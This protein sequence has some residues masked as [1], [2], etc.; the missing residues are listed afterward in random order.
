LPIKIGEGTIKKIKEKHPNQNNKKEH[1]KTA[2]VLGS[3]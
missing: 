1:L 3:N 2:L